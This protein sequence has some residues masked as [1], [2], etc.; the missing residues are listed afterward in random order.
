MEASNAGTSMAGKQGDKQS[1]L[2]MFEKYMFR[3]IGSKKKPKLQ[4]LWMIH[5][6]DIRKNDRNGDLRFLK[7]WLQARYATNADD[8]RK[9][10]MGVYQWVSKWGKNL[11]SKESFERL[12]GSELALYSKLYGMIRNATI[13]MDPNLY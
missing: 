7:A 5:L 4:G 13:V 10:E 9:I 8:C 11:N 3:K 6:S 12:L 2:E 1:D